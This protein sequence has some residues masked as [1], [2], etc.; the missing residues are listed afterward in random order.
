MKELD[1]S[2]DITPNRDLA[3]RIAA[4]EQKMAVLSAKAATPAPTPAPV[5]EQAPLAPVPQ[6]PA[7]PL[8]GGPGIQAVS[9]TG[10][11]NKS[12]DAEVKLPVSGYMDFHVNKDRGTPWSA[13]FHR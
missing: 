2:F 12:G 1:P 13:D 5:V 11:Y 10:D 3:T 8:I 4:L 7:A 9:I 6:A